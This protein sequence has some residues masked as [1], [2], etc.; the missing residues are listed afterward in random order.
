MGVL[1]IL[2]GSSLLLMGRKLEGICVLI[3]RFVGCFQP[4]TLRF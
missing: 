4:G 1:A 3:D 2:G